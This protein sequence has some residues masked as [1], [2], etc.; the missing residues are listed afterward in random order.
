MKIV[1]VLVNPAVPE[2]IGFSLRALNTMGFD[3]LRIVGDVDLTSSA[4]RKTAY[5]SHHLFDNVESFSSLEEAISDVDVSIGTTAKK[6]TTRNDV[7]ESSTLKSHLI[8]KEIGSVAVVFGSEEN[9]LSTEEINSCHL[10]S[11]IPLATTYPSL[12]LAQSVL[13]YAYELSQL[14]LTKEEGQG[15]EV[16]FKTM[17]EETEQL[18]SRIGIDRSPVLK[19]RIK[20]RLSLVSET[21][22]KLILS[23]INKLNVNLKDD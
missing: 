8:S 13:V 12:N 2:N 9:G 15:K 10:V 7:I 21:D 17:V 22:A 5:G 6:R 19:Q 4:I 18:L 20:D 1:F 23:V 11:T 14:E 16:E 3:T